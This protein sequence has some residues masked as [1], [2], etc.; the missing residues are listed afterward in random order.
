MP[1]TVSPKDA[2]QP[3]PSAY[4]WRVTQADG[5]YPDPAGKADTFRWWDGDAWTRF[6]SADPAAPPPTDTSPTDSTPTE[7]SVTDIPPSDASAMD[8]P[9]T[10]GSATDTPP[11]DA[12][13]PVAP[14][15]LDGIPAP[16]QP[17]HNQPAPDQP[18]PRDEPR[19][20]LAVA[21]GSVVAVLLVAIVA[22]GA[23]VT[24]STRDLPE[25]PAAAPALPPTATVSYDLDTRRARVGEVSVTMPA[26]PYE[27][28][29]GQALTPT[30]SDA[31][32][33]NAL[34]FADYQGTEDWYAGLGFGLVSQDLQAG[35]DVKA[36]TRNVFDSLQ[37]Q[38]Y[39][40]EATTA[41]NFLYQELTDVPTTQA[42]ALAGELHYDIEG[43]ES[44][45]DKVLIIVVKLDAGGYVAWF[46]ARPDG[47]PQATVDVLNDSL[48]SFGIRR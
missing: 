39:A 15:I 44:T 30:F 46:S 17:G 29:S 38:F 48:N 47:A 19:V 24:A 45:Y 16:D 3:E 34:V 4:P 5:W 36:T 25:G 28:Q 43:L 40:D 26:A 9:P 6:L 2:P 18:Q 41:K 22:V 7:A 13:A 23:V 20:R 11:T 37:K 33:C 35:D 1:W 31:A 8:T 27:C 14:Q 42:V 12:P 32:V 21:V 10:D